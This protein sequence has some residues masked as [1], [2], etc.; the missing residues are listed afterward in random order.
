MLH[1][2]EVGQCSV[3]CGL[4]SAPSGVGMGKIIIDLVE[5]S[6]PIP[7][8]TGYDLIVVDQNTVA[9]FASTYFGY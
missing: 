5:N 3:L 9:D 6:T 1:D 4:V 8:F 2:P 7:C